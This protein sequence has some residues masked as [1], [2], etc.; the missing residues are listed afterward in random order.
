MDSARGEDPGDLSG[1]EASA[2]SLNRT[3]DALTT[4]ELAGPSL[5][6]GWSRAHVVAHLALNGQAMAGVADG[7]GRGTTPAM[8]ESDEQRSTDIDELAEADPADLR[9]RLFAATTLFT[10]AV[11][12][13]PE[14]RWVGA[15]TRIPGGPTWPAATLVATR[16]RELEIHHAD[17]GAAYTHH[18]WPDDFVAE[19]LDVVSVD[20]ASSGP[21]LVRAT[22]L[23]REW[24]VGGEDGPVVSGRG[25]DL[26]WWL[27]G[28]GPGDGIS[29][30]SGELPHLGPW[31]RATGA[32][33]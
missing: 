13:V 23:G 20:Q 17:L 30:E 9:D 12:L 24:S 21:F 2:I 29:C 25:A 26:G 11:E 15:F 28:R 16:R 8:Y 3:V 31:R 1:L 14:D 27:T 5:L 10:D 33:S 22:D 4:E 32:V 7:V 19:L 18:D 6:P